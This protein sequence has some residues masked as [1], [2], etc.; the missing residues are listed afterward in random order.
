MKR[1]P[2]KLIIALITLI[3]AFANAMGPAASSGGASP[4]G[5][6]FSTMLASGQASLQGAQ[7]AAM[8]IMQEYQNIQTGAK[9]S[10]PAAK[11]L[12]STIHSAI[13]SA[14]N[15]YNTLTDDNQKNLFL[16]SLAHE[17]QKSASALIPQDVL[18]A[19]LEG[20]KN[21]ANNL[22][23]LGLNFIQGIVQNIV[24]SLFGAADSILN[25]LYGAPAPRA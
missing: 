14:Q 16:A 6:G 11:A 12:G 5:S 19:Q 10:D 3:P 18:Q 4:Q 25:I 2:I 9:A 17:A 8:P 23:Q 22:G 20:M 21:Q 24:S 15:H 7:Q 13:V 1:R